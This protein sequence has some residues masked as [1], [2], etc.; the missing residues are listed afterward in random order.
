MMYRSDQDII[1]VARQSNDLLDE[2]NALRRELQEYKRKWEEAQL[3]MSE[4]NIA[5]D[6]LAK[7]VES[8]KFETQQEM[9]KLLN[10]DI[11][12]LLKEIRSEKKPEKKQILAEL[13]IEQ[14]KMLYV[15]RGFK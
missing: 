4:N 7:N 5:L 8:I 12:P 15:F 14:L 11:L 3:E 10:S 2:N 1:P 6:A 9:V 13:A